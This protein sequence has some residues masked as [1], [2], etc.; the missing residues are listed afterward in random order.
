MKMKGLL[1][2]CFLGWSVYTLSGDGEKIISFPDVNRPS[3]F[4]VDGD[5]LFINEQFTIS[6]YSLA[7]NR[8][9]K[10]FGS[11]GEGPREFKFS[12]IMY[13]IPG[14]LAVISYCKI[15]YYTRDGEYIEEKRAPI[16][17]YPGAKI[18]T[19]DLFV[20]LKN[21]VELR[22]SLWILNAEF[23]PIIEV[24]EEKTEHKLGEV[25]GNLWIFIADGNRIF[26]VKDNEFQV[27]IYDTGGKEV[28]SIS[29]EYE[30]LKFTPE[31]KEEYFKS[32][33]AQIPTGNSDFYQR[34]EKYSIF[35]ECL[36]AIRTFF[37]SGNKL[38]IGT[39]GRENG[40]SEVFVYS[41]NGEFL[42]RILL[43]LTPMYDGYM[44]NYPF[45]IKDGK[46]YQLIENGTT[47]NWELH[48]SE[49]KPK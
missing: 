46:L 43:P 17:F 34:I 47:G 2:L 33:K 28:G 12:A 22:K 44:F 36:P 39:F 25:M 38:Y 30:R 4:A 9:I 20:S 35:P 16:D 45:T 31:Y 27:G 26:S 19:K 42:E 48:I 18:L 13:L 23:N 41:T 14:G 3:R 40:K 11:Q 6:V 37:I 29:R 5:R 7:D 49:F 24:Y 10:K 32:I 1:L 21:Y 8:L 15:S